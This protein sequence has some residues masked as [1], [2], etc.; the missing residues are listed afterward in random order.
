MPQHA[1]PLVLEYRSLDGK[2][3]QPWSAR[4]TVCVAIG[5]LLLCALIPLGVAVYLAT[6]MGK[7]D[8]AD[9]SDWPRLWALLGRLADAMWQGMAAA[10]WTR[11][12]EPIGWLLALPAVPLLLRAQRQRRLHIGEHEL[13]LTSGL[14]RWLDKG[15]W[16]SWTLPYKTIAS[17]DLVGYRTG[18]SYGPRPLQMAALQFYDHA[19]IVLRRL[20]L[21]P[22][23]RL[24]EPMRP[25]LE[26]SATW[27]GVQ[28]GTW[29]S[30]Q[31]QQTL[32]RAYDA[33]PLVQ[34]LRQRGLAVPALAQGKGSAGDDLFENPRMKTL[35]LLAFAMAP[36]YFAG[37]FLLRE[38]WVVSPP[39]GLWLAIGLLAAIAGGLWMRGTAQDP[40]AMLGLLPV[41]PDDSA[42]ARH[43][44]DRG[45][46]MASQLIVSMLFGLST[47]GAAIP[48]VPFV[49]QWLFAAEDVVFVVRPGAALEPFMPTNDLPSFRPAQSVD[50][51][52]SR[53]PGTHYTLRMRKL[54]WGYW[55]YGVDA[56]RTE[57]EA[58]E[59]PPRK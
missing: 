59:D 45:A 48:A 46:A 40:R 53:K 55:Q 17:V 25:R 44:S 26:S 32:A 37:A 30:E 16:G 34:A 7:F 11:W 27:L 23:H 57:I 47:V 21:A 5:A 1:S 33:L 20:Q 15:S 31:D 41:Q 50:F 42:A 39:V 52:I 19:G 54:P 14:P 4:K 35:I 28:L 29:S 51:W 8:L 12:I 38:Y 49:N 13:H 56:F 43:S 2:P 18:R 10:S 58:F 24:D 22:W 9:A 6:V 3:M 36:I